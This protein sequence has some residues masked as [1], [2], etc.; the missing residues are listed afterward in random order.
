MVGGGARVR[1]V[2]VKAVS[3]VER[4]GE[5]IKRRRRGKEERREDIDNEGSERAGRRGDGRRRERER[6]VTL[7]KVVRRDGCET[8]DEVTWQ[9]KL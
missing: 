7:E 1:E 6:R 4:A 5:K 9:E 8:A 3:G 2:M